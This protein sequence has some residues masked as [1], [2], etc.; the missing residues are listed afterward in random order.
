MR[1][2]DYLVNYMCDTVRDN[3]IPSHNLCVIYKIILS[4]NVHITVMP[5]CV[6]K[7][8][9]SLSEGRYPKKPVIMWFDNVSV[10]DEMLGDRPAAA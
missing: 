4:L 7:I 10:R 8:A 3:E 9:P 5:E 1:G 2:M 6:V